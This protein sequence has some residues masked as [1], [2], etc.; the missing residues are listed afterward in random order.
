VTLATTH[1]TES[2]G[3]VMGTDLHVVLLG[4][5][6]G[7]H[8]RI[9]ARLAALE[10]RWS[11]FRPESEITR[12]NRAGGAHVPLS[13][14]TRHLLAQLVAGW[15]LTAGR[16]D[17]TVLPALV[18]A[19]YDRSFDRLTPPAAPSAPVPGRGLEGLEVDDHGARLPAGTAID[20]GGL[21]KGLA[22]DL[23]AAEA[24]AAGWATGILVNLGG[25]L[26]AAGDVPTPGWGVE[27]DDP[28]GA[29]IGLVAGGLA[30][31]TTSR[32]RWTTADGR[33]QHH[34]IDPRT[35]APAATAVR[36]VTVVAGEAWLAEVLA[37]ALL[38]DGI[39]STELVAAAGATGLIVDHH[40]T[41][42]DLP[43]MEDY[44]W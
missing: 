36:S 43:G 41:V 11:R 14:D 24:L 12:L 26:R 5:A 2:T 27:L 20:P 17:P 28:A 16:F 23:V 19:G 13:A 8:D 22:A 30:S 9:A 44:R 25:D 6:P 21:G 40:G 3:R 18:A 32:R 1:L 10:A 42:V 15:R 29:T 34:V 38:L 35:G 7:A 31:S 39:R 33:E 37:T 4:A